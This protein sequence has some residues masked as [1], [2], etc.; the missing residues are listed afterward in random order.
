[1]W[2]DAWDAA[3]IEDHNIVSWKKK[4]ITI[5]KV[6]FQLTLAETLCNIWKIK[7]HLTKIIIVF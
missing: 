3:M 2:I 4:L 7:Y 6:N 1:M 5:A